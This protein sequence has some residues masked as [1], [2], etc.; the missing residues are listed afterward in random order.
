MELGTMRK[1]IDILEHAFAAS[2][3]AYYNI[4]LTQNLVPGSMYQVIDDKEYSVNEQM[5]LPENAR[6]TDVVSFWGEKL[7]K[8][9]QQ[10]YYEFLS[11]PKLLEHYH[12]GEFNIN[13]TYWTKSVLHKPMLAQ[14]HIMMYED[15]KT[16]DILAITYLQ[17]MTQKFREEEY[18]KKLVQKQQK[19]EAALEEAEKVKQYKEIQTTVEAVDDILN[20]LTF[21]D[22]ISSEEELNQIMPDLMASLGR[23]SMS[24]RAYVFTWNSQKHQILH[25]THEWCAEGILP[26]IE[27]MQELKMSD[28]PNWSPKLNKGESIICADWDAEKEKTPEEYAVFDGQDIHSLIVIPIFAQNKLNGYIGF[29]NPEQSRAAL[30]VRLLSSIGG[31]ISS[32]KDNFL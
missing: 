10:A 7:E 9:E 3:G 22:K 15:E 19:L 16:G 20:K 31:H 4:N 27:K 30:S 18:E 5:G 6:F 11:I 21:F 17:D 14:Q 32:L 12:Q 25:M 28:M 8:K 29:D 23:Y 13:H 1:K 26:T 2:A 24:D